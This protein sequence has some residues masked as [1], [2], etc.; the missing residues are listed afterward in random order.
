ML[1]VKNDF[2]IVLYQ[3][4]N[5]IN[6]EALLE[7]DTIWLTL[8]NL[9][10]LYKRNKSTISRHINNIFSEGELKRELV[11]A[12]F[13]TTTQH[14]AI[15]GKTQTHD[16]IYYNLDVIIAV[17]YRV[18]SQRGQD[19]RKW[20]N[21]IIKNHILRANSINVRVNKVEEEIFYLKKKTDE[22]DT[23]VKG[24]LPP[25][26]GIFYDGQIFDA[27]VFVS[28]LIKLAKNEIIMIDNYIDETVLTLL[29]KRNENVAATIYTA[30]ISEKLKLDLQRHNSQ[31]RPIIIKHS[32]KSHDRFLIIDE[33]VYHIGASLKDLGKKMFAFTKL[34]FAKEDIVGKI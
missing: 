30:K 16:V 23:F 13:A 3:P 1:P 10:D 34:H 25:T 33:E 9:S 31:Y 22:L 19:F 21:V 32:N 28:G 14:G 24:K 8:D 6:I 18:K 4:D 11:V 20:A 15:A 27:Y 5:S 29:D 7:N 17:G 12:F 26:E 2:E